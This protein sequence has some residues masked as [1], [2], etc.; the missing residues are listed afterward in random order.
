MNKKYFLL[1]CTCAGVM[2]MSSCKKFVDID[3]PRNS[4]T[5]DVLFVDS[6]SA[7]SAL[8]GIYSR[9]MGVSIAPSFGCGL[10]TVYG[11]QS[12][13]ELI[14]YSSADQTFYQNILVQDNSTIKSMWEQ[15]YSYIYLANICIEGLE[16]SNTIPPVTKSQFL[17]EAKLVRAF[18]YFYLINLYGDVPY[19]TTSDW[20]T[21]FGHGRTPAAT[22][23][24]NIIA[25]L[26]V[27][28]KDLPVKY[29]AAGKI[30]PVKLAAT[31]MLARVYLY[32]KQWD[33]AEAAATAVITAGVYPGLVAPASAFLKNNDE[34]IWQLT[35]I[36]T[37]YNT[38][39]G[40]VLNAAGSSPTYYFQPAL[41][42]AFEPG[43]LRYTNW[44]KTTVY[45]GVTY[46][47]TYKYKVRTPVNGAITENYTMLRLAEQYLIRA[48]ARNNQSN[49]A[50]AVSD[51][52]VIRKRAA[53]PALSSTLDK[54]AVTA[55]IEKERRVEL[56]CE[57]GHRWLD[58]KRTGR[59][60]A[61]LA[62]VK[63]QWKPTAVWYPIP[64]SERTN[65]ASLSQND[66]YE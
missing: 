26:L 43:D 65:D 19:V 2:L 30:R 12:A 23:Y 39:E 52:N 18:F 1:L 29:P 61:V 55:A 53:L 58:L 44:V 33:K 32:T 49:T 15:A 60:N 57:W 51:L 64:L 31:A 5:R 46:Y 4:V 13:D 17:A 50:D 9:I 6:A 24:E 14:S 20:R 11:A 35:P 7:S 59:A 66:G 34:A 3:A 48:E 41:V 25:D 10:V 37:S 56:F 62:P 28:Q 38:L 42:R 21:S 47:Y 27:A 63:P 54:D 40:Y 8:L 16:Q 36:N 22:I 45:Q